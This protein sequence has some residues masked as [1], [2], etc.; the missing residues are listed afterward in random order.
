MTKRSTG[1]LIAREIPLLFTGSVI[2][3]R[4]SGGKRSLIGRRRSGFNEV[5]IPGLSLKSDLR[6]SDLISGRVRTDWKNK[7]KEKKTRARPWPN[8][9]EGK[10]MSNCDG[11]RERK[12]ALGW[13]RARERR[14]GWSSIYTE[15]ERLDGGSD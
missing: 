11:E 1:I 10:H 3:K 12:E 9:V 14:H 7:G 6:R 2:L 4:L 15:F 8:V 13:E 5:V